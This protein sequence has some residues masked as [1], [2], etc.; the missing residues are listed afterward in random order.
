MILL[1]VP[2]FAV[3]SSGC[4]PEIQTAAPGTDR[5]PVRS[6]KFTPVDEYYGKLLVQDGEFEA[7]S[8]TKPWSSWWYPVRE[9]YLFQSD[10]NRLSPLEK[11][12]RLVQRQTGTLPGAA[13]YE[14]DNLYDSGANAWEGLCNAWAIASIMV[15]Q[16]TRPLT[17][18]GI[19]FGVGDLKALLIKSFEKVEGTRAFG[20][21]YNGDRMSHFDDLYPDQFHGVLVGE[22][23]TKGRPFIIDKDPGV[24]V[25]NTPVWKVQYTVQRDP[26]D[27]GIAHV[28][29]WLFGASPF[30]DSYDYVGTLSVVFEYTYD[31]MGEALPDG[32]LQVHYGSWTGSSADFHPDFVT[33]LPEPESGSRESLNIKL[34]PAIIDQILQT[35]KIRR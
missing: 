6:S 24:P 1:F 23:L 9:N 34:Q 35:G 18:E 29:T 26:A 30:V 2:L 3:S 13:A 5:W 27:A 15:P 31:L 33:I 28:K 20:Q 17:I 11:Y 22:L 10:G 19:Q 4:G 16:P 12:D 21:R 32:S 8:A 25:W 14:R 7:E